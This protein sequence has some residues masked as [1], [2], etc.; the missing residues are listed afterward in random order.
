MTFPLSNVTWQPSYRIISISFPTDCFFN[1]S[2]NDWNEQHIRHVYEL[3][4][5]G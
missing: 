1:N 3:T 2:A 5:L 4:L